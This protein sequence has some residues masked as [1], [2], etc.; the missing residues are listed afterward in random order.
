MRYLISNTLKTSSRVAFPGPKI[1]AKS[2]ATPMMTSIAISNSRNFHTRKLHL[3]YRF[4]KQSQLAEKNRSFVTWSPS[5]LILRLD[6]SASGCGC[7]ADIFKQF[8]RE[9][10]H[11]VLQTLKFWLKLKVSEK[12]DPFELTLL[13]AFAAHEW[14]G[15]D[16]SSCNDKKEHSNYIFLYY[17]LI[18]SVSF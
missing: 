14:H 8:E 4:W 18:N 11:Y 17:S 9:S 6:Q 5:S 15:K 2:A 3:R 7:T 12:F 13:I 1:A 16:R 10:K